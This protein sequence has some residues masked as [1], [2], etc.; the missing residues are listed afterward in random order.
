MTR[1]R[2]KGRQVWS[3]YTV[4]YYS[5]MKS[6]ETLTPVRRWMNVGNVMLS[7]G[8]PSQKAAEYIPFTGNV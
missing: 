2:L 1:V 5:G 8:S 3:I 6:S 7:D 4:D